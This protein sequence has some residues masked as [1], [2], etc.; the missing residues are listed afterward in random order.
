MRGASA[1]SDASPRAGR[2]GGARRGL[3]A[4]GSQAPGGRAA[5]SALA[6]AKPSFGSGPRRRPRRAALGSVSGTVEPARAPA[7]GRRPRPA[8]RREGRLQLLPHPKS[9]PHTPVSLTPPNPPRPRSGASGLLSNNFPVLP[10]LP[11]RAKRLF[12]V[13]CGPRC[14]L[15]GS[16]VP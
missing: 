16:A 14:L 2:S 5:R 3:G 10:A 1:R 6:P 15:S 11:V 13:H 12:S 9:G 8:R 4:H 7:R